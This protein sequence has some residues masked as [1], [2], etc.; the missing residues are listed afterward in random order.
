MLVKVT[1]G[2]ATR[3][4]V[5]DLR[6]ENP[7]WSFADEPSPECLEEFGVF[8]L[9]PTD[10]PELKYGEYVTEGDPELVDGEWFQTWT[11][12]K[13]PLADI[14]RELLAQLAD[15]RW[16]REVSG[17]VVQGVPIKTDRET[18]SI[19]T[20]LYVKAKFNASFSA[21]FKV[22]SGVFVPV[23]SAQIIAVGD[24]AAAHVQNCFDREKA[25]SE[26]IATAKNHDALAAIDI[27][28]GWPA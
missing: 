12:S 23:S 17:I 22:S 19:L 1:D 27:E 25:L 5:T 9:A 21:N 26:A 28:S 2:K 15:T 18:Q 16:Q 20:S 11:I 6:A 8:S 10:Q 24:A 14:K 3:I 4:T 7:E 13:T